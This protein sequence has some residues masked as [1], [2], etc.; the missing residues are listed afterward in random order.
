[1]PVVDIE[2]YMSDLIKNLQRQFSVRLVYV[3]LQGSF[4]RDEA[5]DTS[6]IDVMVTLDKLTVSDLDRYREVI[7]GMPFAERSCGFISG[8]DELKNWP[9]YEIC[10]LLHETKDY[11][12]ELRPLLPKF[13][14]DDVR[15]YIRTSCGNLYHLL[16]HGRIHAEPDLQTESLR[17]LYKAVFYIL[18]NSYYLRTRQWVMTKAELLSKLQG[19]DYEV[20][21]MAMLMK[22]DSAHD[23]DKAYQVLFDWCQQLLG[24]K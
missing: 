17:G 3:G 18:Q 20:L 10:Q 5:T 21:A 16:C 11:F 4:R 9:P 8:R 7:Y 2:E 1:M 14:L 23:E 13:E 12:G 22:S 15:N 24:A 19:L 6:D